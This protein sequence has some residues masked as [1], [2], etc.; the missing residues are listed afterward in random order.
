MPMD[1]ITDWI[2][3]N[4]LIAEY[5]EKIAICESDKR[6]LPYYWVRQW[7]HNNL[8]KY[9]SSFDDSVSQGQYESKRWLCDELRKIKFHQPSHVDIIGSWFAFPLIEM[10]SN[11]MKIKQIDLF[12]I[13]ENCH[14]VTAQYINHFNFD[15][16]I[17]QFG[18]AFER[19]DWR[20]RHL[21]I[22]TS[23]EHMVDISTIKSHY[24]DY[25][26]TPILAIQSNNYFELDE[27]IN[28]VNNENEL[29]EK[30]EIREVYF[31]GKQ[32]LPMY[33][34]YMVIGRW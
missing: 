13:D 32:S 22:N 25:P 1:Q 34:R 9:I 27:H 15:F 30:N 12:D 10:L 6:E 3:N 11:I 23:S 26:N 19:K 16:R 28:C 7:V 33:D 8:P 14:S 20:R 4:N 21:I 5:R 2:K 18:D 24:K 17:V 31:K 29:I